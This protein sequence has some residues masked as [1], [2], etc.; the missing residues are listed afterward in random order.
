LIKVHDTAVRAWVQPKEPSRA[1][2]QGDLPW[3][4]IPFDER[5]LVFDTETTTDFT[6]RLLFGVFRNYVKGELLQEGLFL[7]DSISEREASIA[8]DYA[9]NHNLSIYTRA[10]FV[11]HIFYPEVYVQ[12]SLCV[13]FNLPFDLS[14]IS[15]QANPSKGKNRRS[16]RLKLSFRVDL[17][18][19]RIQSISSRAAFIQFA[20]K[21]KLQDWEKPFFDGRFLDLSTLASALTGQKF[22]LRRAAFAFKTVHKKSKVDSLGKITAEV[23]AYGRNDVLVTWEL[24]EKLLTE[25]LTYPFA[26]LEHER[27]QRAGGVPITRLYSTASIA[28]AMLHLMGFTPAVQRLSGLDPRVLGWAM[29]AYFGG[30]SEVRTRR[31]D[32]PVRVVDFTSMYPTV[33]ILMNLQELLTAN[34]IAT[35]D[36]TDAVRDLLNTVTLDDLY[37]PAVWAQ[38]RAIV[39]LKPD[40]AVLPVRMR[41]EPEAPYSIAVT[42]FQS[43]SSRWYTLGDVI[44]AKLLGGTIPTIEEAIEFFGEGRQDG[45]KPVD[46]RG[47]TLDSNEQIFKTVVEQRQ[48][49]KGDDPELAQALKILANSGAYGIYAEINVAPTSTAEGRTGIWYADIGPVPG[50]VHDEHPGAFFNPI[51]ASLVTGAARLALAMAEAEVTRRGGTFAFCDTDSLAI[52]AGESAPEGAPCITDSHV[53]DIIVKFNRLNPYH[54]A[55]VPNLLKLEHGGIP[56][57][58]CWAVSA[59]RYVLFTRD[60]RDR[61][62]IVKASESGLGATLGRTQQETIGKLARRMWIS[63]LL[64]ELN[65]KYKGVTKRRMAMLTNFEEPMRRALP[66]ST[67]HVYKARGFTRLNKSKGYD[68]KIKPFGFLQAVT[69]A[70]K[71]GKASLQPIAPFERGLN[72]SKKLPWTD[73]K[74]GEIVTLDWE[75]TAFAGTVPVTRLDE[76]IHDYRRHPEAKASDRNGEAAGKETRGVLG[77]LHLSGGPPRR[78]GKEVDRLDEDD[79]FTLDRPD[80]AQYASSHATLEWALQVLSDQPASGIALRIGMSERRFRDI[81]TRRVRNVRRN[82]R[83]AIIQLALDHRP[84]VGG[85]T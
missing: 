53:R 57:L 22:T 9:A 58:R 40:G 42:P 55:I 11:E 28:K 7:G 36:V 14:R 75:E 32:V 15:V 34:R 37:N 63:I 43:G 54:A 31:V 41:L 44:A 85:P 4:T 2:S 59:K 66:L 13:G 64:R 81:R 26:T 39:K 18:D 6:Q 84:L 73:Y 60:S 49:Y 50:Q 47:V 1:P 51:I 77:R 70:I 56:T 79:E 72:E 5:V 25:Y 83:N 3:R 30:R 80:P 21:M 82:H 67:P 10:E 20:P 68:F 61:I 8:R 33:F 27:K 69:E 48:R 24:F 35:R 52:V 19:V 78:I 76:F 23:I 38:F 12:G 46:L 45:L 16:F 71:V 29:S 62:R 65:L 74:S 17:P